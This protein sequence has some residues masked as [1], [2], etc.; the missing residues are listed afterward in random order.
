MVRWIGSRMLFAAAAGAAAWGAWSVGQ[1]ATIRADVIVTVL[2]LA[3][4]PLLTRWFLG[5]PDN[6]AARRVQAAGYA[7]V[8]ALM[9]A[10]AATDLLPSSAPARPCW[11]PSARPSRPAGAR[12]TAG[13]ARQRPAGRCGGHGLTPA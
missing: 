7:A 11:R 4:L 13:S 8:L 2:L 10:K 6:K 5:P 3:G 1:A 12:A 9:P